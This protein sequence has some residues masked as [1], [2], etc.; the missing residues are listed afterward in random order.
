[1]SALTHPPPPPQARVLHFLSG[2]GA[3]LRTDMALRDMETA[4]LC[5]SGD[6]ITLVRGRYE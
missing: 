4:G 2:K 6:T 1:V 5:C 3:R